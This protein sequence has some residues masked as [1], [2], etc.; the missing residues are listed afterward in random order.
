[1]NRGQVDILVSPQGEVEISVKGI[2]GRKCQDVTKSLEESLG[3]VASTTETA[4]MREVERE[5]T[6]T[7]LAS[8]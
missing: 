7:H 8:Q 5:Q 2:K 4:E 1:M 6:R 3:V